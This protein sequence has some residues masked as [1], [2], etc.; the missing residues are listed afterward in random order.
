MDGCRGVAVFEAAELPKMIALHFDDYTTLASPLADFKAEMRRRG[1][2]DRI[3]ETGRGETVTCEP[4]QSPSDFRVIRRMPAAGV[5]PKLL[6]EPATAVA[7]P[8]RRIGIRDVVA[9]PVSSLR[10]G[11]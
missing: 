7:F 8:T 5:D 9:V 2:A 3:I 1:W 10:K 4:L 11:I 6:I